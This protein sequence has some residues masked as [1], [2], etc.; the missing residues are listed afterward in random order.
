MLTALRDKIKDHRRA[1]SE[2]GWE[3]GRKI[4]TWCKAQLNSKVSCQVR[5]AQ[6]SP[7]AF[8]R[9]AG[10][11]WECCTSQLVCCNANGHHN[12]WLYL[13]PMHIT[14]ATVSLLTPSMSCLDWSP[15]MTSQCRWTAEVVREKQKQCQLLKREMEAHTDFLRDALCLLA[16]LVV[17]KWWLYN[18]R[19]T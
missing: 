16:C 7:L 2:E 8:Q 3:V 17:F 9:E 13:G 5:T 14:I 19:I 15:S 12:G 18:W 10:H 4:S 1:E 6:R 11:P